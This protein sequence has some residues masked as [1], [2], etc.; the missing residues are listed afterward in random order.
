MQHAAT[1]MELLQQTVP[2]PNEAFADLPMLD[3]REMGRLMEL[4]RIAAEEI[5]RVEEARSAE[6][7]GNEK[8]TSG[9]RP[10]KLRD[11]LDKIERDMIREGLIRTHWNKSLLARELDISRS[12]L[13]A[14]IE[15]YGL[16]RAR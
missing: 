12:T 1:L 15:K 16:E 8:P 3:E 10:T 5:G 2:S 9:P 14:K 11:A 4:L 7:A 13:I 6:E